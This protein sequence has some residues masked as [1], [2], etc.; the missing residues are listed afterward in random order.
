MK[1]DI[2][3]KIQKPYNVQIELVRGCN[4]A[5]D[6]CAIHT[7]PKAKHYM[8][9]KVAVRIAKE[10]SAFDPIRI[11]FAMRS[12]P[13]L[14]PKMNM[15]TK[16]IRNYNPKSQITLTTNGSMLTKE[17]LVEFFKFGGNI[18]IVDCYAKK[19]YEIYLKRFEDLGY[20]IYDLYT[21]DFNPW[22]RHSPD[23]KAIVMI[24]DFADGI[25]GKKRSRVLINQAG[26]VDFS[27]TKKYG[28]EPLVEPLKKKCTHPFREIAFFS[29]GNISICCRDWSEKFVLHNIMDGNLKNYWYNDENLNKARLLLYNKDR[30]FGICK[31]CDYHGGM[32]IGFLPK[33]PEISEKER[34]EIKKEFEENKKNFV[35]EQIE[36]ER[37]E[38]GLIWK[39]NHYEKS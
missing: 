13:T 32:R 11:E 5:C 23:T 3:E 24:K 21:D 17:R 4:F 27:L 10:L 16:I 1:E 31:T 35:N 6:F 9:M 25:D 36:A 15:I 14:H 30:D 22:H 26:N 2:G 37:K 34:K 39:G 38:E 19:S 12:E 20:K 8:E 28:L 7:V 18:A 29:N 33:L